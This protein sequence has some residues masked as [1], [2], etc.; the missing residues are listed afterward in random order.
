MI[1]EQES[2]ETVIRRPRLYQTSTQDALRHALLWGGLA[3]DYKT[4]SLY[5]TRWNFNTELLN[6][7]GGHG[8]ASAL[9]FDRDELWCSLI[10]QNIAKIETQQEKY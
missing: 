7:G 9:N 5:S 1:Y 2:V 8:Y 10:A 6:A 4:L 3:P